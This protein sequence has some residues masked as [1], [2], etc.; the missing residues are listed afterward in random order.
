MGGRFACGGSRARAQSRCRDWLRTRRVAPPGSRRT[1][2]SQVSACRDN[3][4]VG[5]VPDQRTNYNEVAG[6]SIHRLA[7]LADGIFAVGMTLL[8]LGLAVPALDAV[9]SEGD[10]LG[11]LGGLLPAV[12]TYFMSFLT[13]GI[14]W[15]AQQTQLGRL[16]RANRNFTWIHLGFLLAVT[17]I[18]FSTALLARFHWSRVALVVY[19]LN[20]FVLG[21][22]VALVVYWLNIFVLGA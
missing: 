20:I 6:S 19:W 12:V 9:K 18:P 15:V 5:S 1:A 3:L 16:E 2:R 4:R 21:A 11:Q 10:L 14:F 22:G 7:G 13:L 17:L 8:V